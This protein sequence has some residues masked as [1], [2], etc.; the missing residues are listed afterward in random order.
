MNGLFVSIIHRP[1]VF[2]FL[3]AYLFLAWRLWGWRRTIIW[4]VSGYLIAWF[5]E[6]SSINNG[7]PYGEYHYVYENLKGELLILG[8]PFFDSLSYPFL[9]FAGFSVVPS[10]HRTIIRV[11]LG[12]LLTMFL[13]VIIDPVATMGD[14]WFLGKIHWYVHPGFYFGV[15]LTNFA[16]WFLVALTV[17]SFNIVT[18]RVFPSFFSDINEARSMKHEA[19]QNWFCPVFY[20]GIALFNIFITFSIGEWCLGLISLVIVCLI[21]ISTFFSGSRNFGGSSNR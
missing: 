7:F 8:V 13:D 12:S 18:W 17:I 11:L 6:Y 9:I 15:P 10:H 21:I 19:R 4:L 14:K 1:Y 2:A 20:A 5:S 3:T 16:G